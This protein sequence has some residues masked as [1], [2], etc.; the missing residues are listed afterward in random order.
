MRSRGRWASTPMRETVSRSEKFG[1]KDGQSFLRTNQDGRVRRARR[2][3]DDSSSAI[4]S[5]LR[6]DVRVVHRISS[7]VLL[8]SPGPMLQN[9]D[10]SV[11]STSY[12]VAACSDECLDHPLMKGKGGP[13]PGGT[14]EKVLSAA[15]RWPPTLVVRMT[16][17]FMSCRGCVPPRRTPHQAQIQRE[18]LQ[19]RFAPTDRLSKPLTR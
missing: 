9:A 6:N 12:P 7:V 4:E 10:W 16:P 3:C 18:P 2:Y 8:S 15:T 14:P 19:R 5:H 1:P 11:T 17:L 13:L